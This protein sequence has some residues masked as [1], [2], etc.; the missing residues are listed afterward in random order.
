LKARV[1]RWKVVKLEAGEIG[2]LTFDEVDR[3]LGAVGASLKVFAAWHGAALDRLLDEAHAILV[4]RVVKELRACG[5]LVEVEV[6]FSSYGERGSIDILAWHPAY[7]ALAVFEIK[8][9]LGGIDPLLRPLDVKVRLAPALARR[10]G[11]QVRRSVSRI[12]VLPADRSA[13]RAVKRHQTVLDQALPS[14]TRELRK[15]VNQPLGSQRG[16]WFM[17]I[18]GGANTKPNPSAV[19]RVRPPSSRSTDKP[20][21]GPQ[22]RERLKVGSADI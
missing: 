3:C 18:V 12:V 6:T 16:I 9:E 13:R 14:R 4:G 5:W 19:R 10:L 20:P 2:G 8:S 11:W 17:A 21:S 15:W 22:R 7:E 1:G